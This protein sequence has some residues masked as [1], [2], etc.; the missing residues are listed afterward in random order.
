VAWLAAALPAGAPFRVHAATPLVLRLT[1]DDPAVGARYLAALAAEHAPVL[2]GAAA[3]QVDLVCRPWFG[4]AEVATIALQ[5]VKVA[6]HLSTGDG[7]G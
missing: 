6:H 7:G 3:G 4:T 2:R 1:F 5:V